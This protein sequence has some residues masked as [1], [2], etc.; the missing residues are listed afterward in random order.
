MVR[1]KHHQLGTL[2]R[3][4][5]GAS[6][7]GSYQVTTCRLV[8]PIN[9]DRQFNLKARNQFRFVGQV[10]T[11][12]VD[13]MLAVQQLTKVCELVRVGVS[14]PSAELTHLADPPEC[15]ADSPRP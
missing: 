3:T 4:A 12:G 5:T 7:P 2:D 10:G 14:P 15:P 1:G 13:L 11:E 8:G 9:S 6:R